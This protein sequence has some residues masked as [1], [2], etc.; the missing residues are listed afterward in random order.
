MW[1]GGWFAV[2]QFVARLKL[3][4]DATHII[5]NYYLLTIIQKIFADKMLFS[6]VN[7]S[8]GNNNNQPFGV[9]DIRNRTVFNSC[10]GK[11]LCNLICIWVFSN[12]IIHAN[13]INFGDLLLIIAY[14]HFCVSL[15]QL[16]IL[17]SKCKAMGKPK[18][19]CFYF[20]ELREME[21][22]CIT[23]KIYI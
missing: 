15:Q 12:L 2:T 16:F 6:S 1:N 17:N 4:F 23:P 11:P 14:L 21:K 5:F 18:F 10:F 13:V 22:C 7:R 20:P 9:S 3:E 19:A 8:K